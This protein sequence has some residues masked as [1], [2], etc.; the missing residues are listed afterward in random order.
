MSSRL[1]GDRLI[2]RQHGDGVVPRDHLDCVHE[3]GFVCGLPHAVQQPAGLDPQAVM[4]HASPLTTQ[5]YLDPRIVRPKD[6]H[7]AL[8]KVS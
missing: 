1:A 5:R 6:V 2:G 8:P 3:R 4:D 7:A